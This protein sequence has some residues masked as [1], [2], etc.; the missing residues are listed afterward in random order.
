M[1]I[2]N[3][4]IVNAKD[5]KRKLDNYE[6]QIDDYKREIDY[7]NKNNEHFHKELLKE[8]GIENDLKDQLFRGENEKMI[9]IPTEEYKELLII[10]GK[11]EELKSQTRQP[12]IWSGYTEQGTTILPCRDTGEFQT[13]SPV[14][15]SPYKITCKGDK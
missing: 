2:F 15:T 10:K 3:L 5:Y 12:I 11:Y 14:T 1:Q 8:Y 4:L 9:T 13:T 7:L 6:I